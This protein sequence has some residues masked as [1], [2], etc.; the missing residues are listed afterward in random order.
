MIG[1][2]TQSIDTNREHLKCLY[3]F[4]LLT[5]VWTDVWTNVHLEIS[6]DGWNRNR[7]KRQSPFWRR[8]E[9]LS[10]HCGNHGWSVIAILP[11][12]FDF[13]YVLRQSWLSPFRNKMAKRCFIVVEPFPWEFLASNHSSHWSQ[14]ML[15]HYSKVSMTASIHGVVW[16]KT[17]YARQFV[18]WEI[19]PERNDSGMYGVI[20]DWVYWPISVGVRSKLQQSSAFQDLQSID[21]CPNIRVIESKLLIMAWRG[22]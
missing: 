13:D 4:M 20:Y 6:T 14:R 1:Y 2:Q 12:L 8:N 10:S 3:L 9:T 16:L 17:H 15:R 7:I 22:R 5:D 19:G 18:W 21:W 11:R